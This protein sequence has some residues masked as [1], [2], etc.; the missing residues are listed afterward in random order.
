MAYTF[1]K[2]Q[3]QAVGSSLVEAERST[4][5]ASSSSRR[6]SAACELLLP[7]DHL[8]LAHRSASARAARPSRRP[9]RRAVGVDIGPETERGFARPRSPAK[10]V[11]WNGPMGIFEI[12][13]F[14]H[15]TMAMV[16]ALV[17]SAALTIVG[18]GDS[19][20][21]VEQSGRADRHHAHL[22]RRRRIARVPRGRSASR[23]RRARRRHEPHAHPA[24]R[25]QLEDA[26]HRGRG[27]WRSPAAVARGVRER[28]DA[29][30]AGRAALHRARVVAERLADSQSCSPRRTCTGRPKGRSPARCRG[31]CC[32]GGCTHVI[33]GHSERRQFFGETTSRWRGRSRAALR[34]GLTPIVCVGE[35]LPE[36][37]AGETWAVIDRQ[38]RRGPARPRRAA[39]A[40]RR[41]RLRAGVGHRHRQ[42]RDARAGPGGPRLIRGLLA[43]ARRGQRCRG[44]ASSM[45]AASSPTTS[46]R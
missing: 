10:T 5:T 24:H 31:R 14:S 39:I 13:P 26:R 46:T 29:R 1:L 11:F 41:A 45:V 21:A 32:R 7:V 37:E 4:S 38:V 42:G 20:A 6:G 33:I 18:G 22:H 19:V 9:S 40:A 36:R 35:T 23:R 3:W 12:P 25:R 28:R 17:Q 15:G 30:G 2:A 8:R 16:D 44:V 34:A 43:R 27:A